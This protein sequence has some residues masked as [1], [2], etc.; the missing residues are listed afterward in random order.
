MTPQIFQITS[1]L[2]RIETIIY[3]LSQVCGADEFSVVFVDEGLQLG[4]DWSGLGGEG[5]LLCQKITH[6]TSL[7]Q[8]YKIMLGIEILRIELLRADRS[9][10]IWRKNYNII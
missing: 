9:G 4:V 10:H 1:Y 3:G 2:L 7:Q 8:L 6:T 5:V